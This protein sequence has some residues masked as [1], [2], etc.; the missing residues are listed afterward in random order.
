MSARSRWRLARIVHVSSSQPRHG[1]GS[2]AHKVFILRTR[3]AII[4][5]LYRPCRKLP[6]RSL[7]GAPLS[8]HRR[9][10]GTACAQARQQSYLDAK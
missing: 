8:T 3:S 10:A 5:R 4:G 9:E 7:S 6:F 1:G 2:G